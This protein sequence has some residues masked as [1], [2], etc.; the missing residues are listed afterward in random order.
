M[1]QRRRETFGLIGSELVQ[2]LDQESMAKAVERLLVGVTDESQR[3]MIIGEAKREFIWG[4]R[5][6]V[7]TAT[8]LSKKAVTGE[9]LLAAQRNPPKGTHFMTPEVPDQ[10]P[11]VQTNTKG[12][13]KE[14]REAGLSLLA[15][16]AKL[17]GKV[18]TEDFINSIPLKHWRVLVLYYGLYKEPIC[19]L[20]KLDK[21]LRKEGFSYGKFRWIAM[22]RLWAKYRFLK[23]C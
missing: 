17:E 22:M 6:V 21:K 10:T 9:G 1:E 4:C 12:N 20:R 7:T 19:D 3:N 11:G 13:R 2:F 8:T 23:N 14:L 16:H 18:F 5:K 15:K